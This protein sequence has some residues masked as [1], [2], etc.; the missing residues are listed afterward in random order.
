MWGV[1]EIRARATALR[2]LFIRGSYCLGDKNLGPL[3]IVNPPICGENSPDKHVRVKEIAFSSDGLPEL[4][5]L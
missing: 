1:S 2:V 4:L 5:Q 3:S